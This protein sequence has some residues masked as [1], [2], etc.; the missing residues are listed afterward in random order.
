MKLSELHGL[1]D[2]ALVL[3]E[4]EGVAYQRDLTVTAQYDESYWNK[5]SGYEGTEICDAI[6]RGRVAF[7][8]K[9]AGPAAMVCDVG[10]GSGEF[11]RSRGPQTY[12]IDVNPAAMRWLKSCGR[13]ANDLSDFAVFT[14]WDVLEHCPD[15]DEYLS[16][17]P[18]GGW[19]FISIPIF[20]HLHLIRSSRHYRPGEHL[21]YFRRDGLEGWLQR[22]GFELAEHSL[23]ETEAGR[24]S[25]HSFAFRRLCI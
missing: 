10:V 6:N 21:F 1:D 18:V 12:G 20:E 15:P 2:E 17:I 7:V 25:I 19:A 5:C 23:F 9:H 14:F 8:A 11:I 4:C 22:S 3:C 13:W 16:L 24:D